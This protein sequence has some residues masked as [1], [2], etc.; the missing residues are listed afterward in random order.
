[1]AVK[2]VTTQSVAVIGAGPAGLYAARELANSGLEVA[3]INRDIKPGGLAEYGIHYTKQK[4]KNGLRRQFNQI[5]GMP[6]VHYFGNIE[7]GDHSDIS[8]GEILE[9]GFGAVLVAVGAQGTKWL[10]LPGENL[11]GVYHAKELA[12]HYNQLPPFSQRNYQI[13]QRVA[14]I[15]VGNVMVD[16]ANWLINDLKVEFVSAIARRGPAAVK[17]KK[18]EWLAIAANLDQESF[19]DEFGRA[20]PIMKKVGQDTLTAK[21]F[22]LDPIAQAGEKL[23]PTQFGFHFLANPVR[24]LGDESGQACGLQVEETT[25]VHGQ[26]GGTKA[27]GTGNLRKLD[28]DTIIFC[29]GDQVDSKFGLP[30]DKWGEFAKN[31]VPRYPM[32]ATSYE[33]YDSNTATEVAGV[34][35]AGWARHPSS[36]LVGTARKDG[37]NSAKAIIQYLESLPHVFEFEEVLTRLRGRLVELEEP[38]VTKLDLEALHNFEHQKAVELGLESFKFSTNEEMLEAIGHVQLPISSGI[39]VA[40]DSTRPSP[41][42]PIHMR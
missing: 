3:I 9:L 15:G 36:G 12:Y 11:Q 26:D 21:A 25:L 8:L 7:V 13:G 31:P 30:L 32:E 42:I 23:S 20:E 18:M 29:I 16:I 14:L 10:G 27:I 24:I 28:A 38:V 39:A 37:A 35:L 17:F 40:S 41:R 1:M 19:N 2:D 4:M 34:F 22:I 6:N 33:A 5:M